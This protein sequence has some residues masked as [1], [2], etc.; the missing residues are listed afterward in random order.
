MESLVKKYEEEKLKISEKKENL[1][2]GEREKRKKREEKLE[3]KRQLEE[4]WTMIRC[5][6]TSI[7][8]NQD[9]WDQDREWIQGEESGEIDK[10][11]EKPKEIPSEAQLS[12]ESEE[13]N[14]QLGE[15]DTN[16]NCKTQQSSEKS[17][18]MPP[19]PAAVL[20]EA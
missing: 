16:V 5:L 13:N 7:D 11:V 4:Y 2:R 6:I 15:T 17:E 10:K 8:E 12:Q 20:S 19:K 3:R 14:I 18:E 9:Q 1:E